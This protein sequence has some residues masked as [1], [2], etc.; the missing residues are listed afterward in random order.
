[1]TFIR[2][3]KK[4]SDQGG[5]ERDGWVDRSKLDSHSSSTFG[6]SSSQSLW[7]KSKPINFSERM[8]YSCFLAAILVFADFWISELLMFVSALH[9][10]GGH[11]FGVFILLLIPTLVAP[12]YH[13][14]T[15]LYFIIKSLQ[16]PMEK[17]N[18][19]VFLRTFLFIIN[20]DILMLK[21]YVAGFIE[22]ILG[23]KNIKNIPPKPPQ[24]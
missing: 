21:L 11:H 2:T 24:K 15:L 20:D 14:E 1:M 17:V 22:S 3:H 5:K 8:L 6:F 4:Y 16:Y 13:L 23:L 18:F 7:D 19:L 10:G 9:V 12:A